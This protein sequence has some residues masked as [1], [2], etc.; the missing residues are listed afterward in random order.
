MLYEV[1]PDKIDEA[2]DATA[3]A[4]IG[5]RCPL[6]TFMFRNEPDPLALKR[7]FY[8]SLVTSCSKKVVIHG[9]SPVW[10]R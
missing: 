4:F 2:A 10:R 9:T 3:D 5:A 7:K 6:G 8:R 1:P